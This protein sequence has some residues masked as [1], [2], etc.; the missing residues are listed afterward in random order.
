MLRIPL[1]LLVLTWILPS[2][3]AEEISREKAIELVTERLEKLEWYAFIY[4]ISRDEIAGTQ[5][6][7]MKKLVLTGRDRFQITD[8]E[9]LTLNVHEEFYW[10]TN[11]KYPNYA[12]SRELG[13]SNGKTSYNWLSEGNYTHTSTPPNL[14]L[15]YGRT[16]IRALLDTWTIYPIHHF[17]RNLEEL[18]GDDKLTFTANLDNELLS[19]HIKQ[20]WQHMIIDLKFDVNKGLQYSSRHSKDHEGKNVFIVDEFQQMKED[21][22]VPKKARM[23]TSKDDIKIETYI[24]VL[25]VK[26]N[27]DINPS[28][29]RN[30]PW[31]DP[32][33]N[34]KT[35]LNVQNGQMS[36][37]KR[38]SFKDHPPS[39]F[40]SFFG[41]SLDEA[42]QMYLE[43]E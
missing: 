9:N 34:T 25:K 30:F 1:I 17:L 24:E 33:Y 23:I 18:H 41:L 21:I 16:K 10:F 13:F 8:T 31:D 7:E 22:W 15:I 29:Y 4:S 6:E 36:R 43:I 26:V 11:S 38:L 14:N 3:H 28:L 39:Y 32:R 42:Y 19:I 12:P 40:T 2:S 37:N 35:N 20:F 5:Y 27:E